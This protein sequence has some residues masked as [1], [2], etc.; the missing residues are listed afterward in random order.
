MS[1]LSSERPD[2]GLIPCPTCKGEGDVYDFKRVYCVLKRVYRDCPDCRG[3]RRIPPPL[4]FG[5]PGDPEPGR[6]DRAPVS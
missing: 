1:R 3:K 5:P 2:E 6:A 4:N